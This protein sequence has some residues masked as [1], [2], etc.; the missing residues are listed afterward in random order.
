MAQERT[1]TLKITEEVYRTREQAYVYRVPGIPQSASSPAHK[2]IGAGLEA[3]YLPLLYVRQREKP[4]SAK[5]KKQKNGHNDQPPQTHTIDPQQY[6]RS[7]KFT[8]AAQDQP[9]TS[10][11]VHT[12]LVIRLVFDSMW[13][14]TTNAQTRSGPR[15]RLGTTYEQKTTEQPKTRDDGIHTS[16]WTVSR[17]LVQLSHGRAG[18]R[19]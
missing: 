19:V 2:Y 5:L 1:A 17:R 11:Q 4:E 7:T 9:H 8:P 6:K 10:Y 18:A 3:N 16:Q 14:F 12:Y 15:T 13:R